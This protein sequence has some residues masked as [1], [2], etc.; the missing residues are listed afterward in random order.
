MKPAQTQSYSVEVYEPPRR[1]LRD[2]AASLRDHGTEVPVKYKPRTFRKFEVKA[3]SLASARR[4]VEERLRADNL[5]VR[6]INRGLRKFIVYLCHPEDTA[7]AAH[8][9]QRS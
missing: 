7:H 4:M 5:P 9:N 2:I 1:Q 6:S 3:N 8:T